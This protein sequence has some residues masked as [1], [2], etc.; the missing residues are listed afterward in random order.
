MGRK[1]NRSLNVSRSR[2]YRPYRGKKRKGPEGTRKLL[3]PGYNYCGPFNPLTKQYLKDF[4][5]VNELDYLCMRHDLEYTYL[6]QRGNSHAEVYFKSNAADEKLLRLIEKKNL[7]NHPQ[8]G[9]AASVVHRAFKNKEVT[10]NAVWWFAGPNIEY[11]EKKLEDL[12]S[13]DM[14]VDE[15]AAFMENMDVDTCP[16]VDLY[17]FVDEVFDPL[18]MRGGIARNPTKY[19]IRSGIVRKQKDPFVN[20]VM[21]FTIK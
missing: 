4:P 16:A 21:K 1:R 2:S 9:R 8:M 11:I 3:Y 5:P 6:L 13:N 18:T 14:E 19:I 17:N 20:R 12:V 7:M 15:K 10:G